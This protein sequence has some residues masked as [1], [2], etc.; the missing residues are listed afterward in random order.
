MPIRLE[1]PNPKCKVKLTVKDHLAGKRVPCPKCKQP[2]L[3]PA[4]MDVEALAAAALVDDGASQQAQASTIDF[5]CPFC[6][7]ALHVPRE[8]GGKQTSC[9]NPECRR[10]VKVPMPKDEKPEDW[11]SL[12]RTGPT[13][14][15]ENVEAPRLEGAW[16]TSRATVSGEALVEAGAIEEDAEPVTAAQ[17]ARRGGYTAAAALVLIAGVLWARWYFA[18][19]R[20]QSLLDQGLSHTEANSKLKPEWKGALERAAGEYHLDSG[21]QDRAR[22]HLAK[23]RHELVKAGGGAERD[24]CLRDVALTQTR[25]SGPETR[26]ELSRTFRAFEGD[27]EARLIAFRDV[28]GKLL[29][30][31]QENVAVGLVQE[32]CQVAK[33]KAVPV[34]VGIK[35]EV[36]DDEGEGE[37]KVVPPPAPQTQPEPASSES[38]LPS[39]QIA[40][41]LLRNKTAEAT[42]LRE[43][44]KDDLKGTPDPLARLGYAEG[45]ARLDKFSEAERLARMPGDPLDRLRT[46]LALAD[47]AR[48]AGKSEEATRF[49]HEG[50]KVFENELRKARIS[51]W[52]VWQLSRSV[53]RTAGD[54]TKAKELADSISDHSVKGRAQLEAFLLKLEGSKGRVEPSMIDATVSDKAI[55]AYALAMEA[56]ARHNTRAGYG[57]DEQNLSGLAVQVRPFVLLGA[58]LGTQDTS[59]K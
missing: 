36:V 58:A 14:A 12:K 31:K 1:C 29:E 26:E 48:G 5:T 2:I 9:S 33:Q 57:G 6:D 13:G 22:T 15:R 19:S 40:L 18:S 50:L 4:P 43:R 51:P 20:L 10:I 54:E 34:G 47:I 37:P 41:Q 7:Q 16:D 25:L 17:W 39:Q 56:V 55:L 46:W 38:L 28:L 42:E 3:I 44:P 45:L 52:L 30:G 32:F 53:A 59:K 23:A 21:Q 11:R 49:T 8:L 27:E 24:A 35:R